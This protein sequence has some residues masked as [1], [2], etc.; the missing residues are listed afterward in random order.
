[1]CQLPLNS[2]QVIQGSEIHT[3]WDSTQAGVDAAKAFIYA[4]GFTADDVKLQRRTSETVLIV[5]RDITVR[6]GSW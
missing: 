2:M 6:E 1:M 5:L 4:N 3:G